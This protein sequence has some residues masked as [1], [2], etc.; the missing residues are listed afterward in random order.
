MNKPS[1]LLQI[2]V[3]IV[4]SAS[5]TALVLMRGRDDESSAAPPSRIVASRPA[6]SRAMPPAAV[7]RDSD[8][9]TPGS[10]KAPELL[11]DL[12]AVPD[13]VQIDRKHPGFA[14]AYK[15]EFDAYR[16]RHMNR[17]HRRCMAKLPPSVKDIE[18]ETVETFS[19]G[20]DGTSM[21]R[22]EIELFP[23]TDDSVAFTNCLTETIQKSPAFRVEFAEAEHGTIQIRN[24]GRAFVADLDA[25]EVAGELEALRELLRDPSSTDDRRALLQDQIE[26]YE[27]Y[28]RLGLAHRADCLAR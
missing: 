14:A 6:E 19:P 10:A 23:R 22:S 8:R 15:K 11:I 5:I 4:L 24:A 17:V 27:C 25:Q 7:T 16:A 3:V 1:R 20:S 28:Q 2:I 13:P 12:D 9:G 21:V 18:W 26:L